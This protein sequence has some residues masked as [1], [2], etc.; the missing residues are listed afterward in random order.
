[1]NKDEFINK[2]KNYAYDTIFIANFW[3]GADIQKVAREKFKLRLP[4]QDVYTV[5]QYCEKNYDAH[6]GVNW[7]FI[8]KSIAAC[9][10]AGTIETTPFPKKSQD[11]VLHG[12]NLELLEK[13]RLAL[14]EYL[15]EAYVPTADK[16]LPYK[17]YA[18]LQGI[19]N[20]LDSW[21]GR[22]ADEGEEHF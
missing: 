15:I 13:Q 10:S 6:A 19:L 1:M 14:S 21:S 3:T 18:A 9:L 2:L 7:K 8:T 4:S 11:V 22:R 12:I 16:T 20:M 17:T 5:A